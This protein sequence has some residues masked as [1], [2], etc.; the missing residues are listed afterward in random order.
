MSWKLVPCRSV[1]KSIVFL[2]TSTLVTYVGINQVEGFHFVLFMSQ[3][4]LLR[5]G[6]KHTVKDKL[7]LPSQSETE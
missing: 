2:N 1:V 5:P 7:Y 3:K 4:L 6:I